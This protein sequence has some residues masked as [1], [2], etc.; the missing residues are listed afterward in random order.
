[1]KRLFAVLVVLALDGCR[2]TAT[3]YPFHSR[4]VY[5][6]P[7]S[8]YRFEV[9]GE[10]HVAPGEDVTSTGSG[11][12]RLCVGATA[13]TLHVSASASAARY[14]LGTTKGSVPW[15]PR[16]REASLRT[17]LGKA[18]AARLD[19]AEIEE[20]VRAVDGVLAG[21]KGTLLGGQTRSL[22]VVTTTLARSTAPGPLTPSACGTF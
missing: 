13:L 9:L 7:R 16:D 14:E 4:G 6:A 10:G 8:G 21:P 19:A 12:V 2:S 5:E 20:S 15:T 11:V 18:G 3:G 1:M 17:L 22:G